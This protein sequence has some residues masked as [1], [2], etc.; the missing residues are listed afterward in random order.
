MPS[1]GYDR[2]SMAPFLAES[3]IKSRDMPTGLNNE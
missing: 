2:L 3:S 1:Y